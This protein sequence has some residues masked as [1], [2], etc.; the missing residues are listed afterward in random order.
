MVSGGSLGIID[1]ALQGAGAL[2]RFVEL[3]VK[4]GDLLLRRFLEKESVPQHIGQARLNGFRGPI[5]GV[6]AHK[7]EVH[8]ARRMR[9]ESLRRVRGTAGSSRNV[10]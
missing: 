6:R 8:N 10:I 5:Q 3:G 4:I 9:G 7:R 2:I 1:E